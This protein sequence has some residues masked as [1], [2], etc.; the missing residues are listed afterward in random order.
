MN[1]YVKKGMV[2]AQFTGQLCFEQENGSKSAVEF[3]GEFEDCSIVF[4]NGRINLSITGLMPATPS[5][6]PDGKD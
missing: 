4:N 2:R 5:D 6:L 3:N 1:G